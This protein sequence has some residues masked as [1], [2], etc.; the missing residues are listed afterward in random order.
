[1]TR[2]SVSATVVGV[3]TSLVLAPASYAQVDIQVPKTDEGEI[4]TRVWAGYEHMFTTDI[5]NGGNIQRDSLLIGL[6]HE[7]EL[8]ESTALVT[9]LTYQLDSYDWSKG[10]K[11][12]G[13]NDRAGGGFRW[14]EIHTPQLVALLNFEVSDNWSLIGAGLV[15]MSAESGANFD[16]A[17]TYAGGAGFM[18]TAEDKK[19]ALGLLGAIVTEIED[20]STFAV[21]PLVTW[22]FADD[23]MFE[24]NTR[25]TGA[26]GYGPEL[27][28][29]PGDSVELA[30]GASYQQR[31]FRLDNHTTKNTGGNTRVKNGVGKDTSVPVYARLGFIPAENIV[32]DLYAGAY[33]TGRVRVAKKGGGKLRNADYDATPIVGAK[34][35]Y[36]F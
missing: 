8:G 2:F 35:E 36:K 17:V 28:W 21:L 34:F 25:Q 1:M 18:W 5:N 11:N 9:N 20:D 15:K 23:W 12:G 19:L 16:D 3:L 4:K 24:L 31:R 26:I 13:K 32:L 27:I 29:T 7:F 10:A 33:A 14:G 22:K 30:L 6:S